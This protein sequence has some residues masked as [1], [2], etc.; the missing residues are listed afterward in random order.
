[1][2]KILLLLLIHVAAFSL[3]SCSNKGDCSLHVYDDAHILSPLD[4]EKLNEPFKGKVY[5]EVYLFIVPDSMS[6]A[7][8]MD[9]KSPNDKVG[10]FQRNHVFRVYYFPRT[11]WLRVSVA[12]NRKNDF[13]RKYLASLYHIQYLTQRTEDPVNIS[14]KPVLANIADVTSSR[15][16]WLGPASSILSVVDWLNEEMILPSYG[17]IHL[18]FFRV[19]LWV[20]LGFVRAF[21]GFGWPI[22]LMVILLISIAILR[23]IF[24][25]HRFLLQLAYALVMISLVC[26]VF[27]TV[28]SFDTIMLVREHGMTDSSRL[29]ASLYSNIKSASPSWVGGLI[30]AV[31]FFIDAGCKM[32]FAYY[33]NK[34]DEKKADEELSKQASDS[35]GGN[36]ILMLILAFMM[37]QCIVWA[38]CAYL[39]TRILCSYFIPRPTGGFKP[40]AS[41]TEFLVA[42]YALAIYVFLMFT[43][44]EF[45]LWDCAIS[46]F[47]YFTITFWHP[48]AKWLRILIDI[49]LVIVVLGGMWAIQTIYETFRDEMKQ[50]YSI[51]GTEEEETFKHICKGFGWFL[52]FILTVHA[53]IYFVGFAIAI[54]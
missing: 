7:E 29:L 40:A 3:V 45:M 2:K 38:V 14:L 5:N 46:R 16:S 47:C 34:N 41:S 10:W 53:T 33:S 24:P 9:Y 11:K 35:L 12:A 1:M 13:D 28:P 48:N 37:P 49:I 4:K 31:L 44:Y 26:M 42:I 20:A 54:G 51:I 18:L 19:P 8:A 23:A 17:F 25:S 15:V 39:F 43:W 27:L 52:L 50:L 30:F 6:Y 32:L 22:A 21:H 36:N